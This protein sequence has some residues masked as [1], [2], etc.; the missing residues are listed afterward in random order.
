M[1]NY[2]NCNRACNHCCRSHCS[3]CPY[4]LTGPP[5]PRGCPG[6]E[7]I[8]GPAGIDGAAG[9]TGATGATGPAPTIEVGE[10]TIGDPGSAPIIVNSGTPEAAVFDF[11]FPPAAGLGSYGGVYSNEEQI[12]NLVPET[13]GRVEM[14][15]ALPGLNMTHAVDTLIIDIPGD[16]QLHFVIE[17]DMPVS[18]GLKAAVRINGVGIPQATISKVMMPGGEIIFM[19][20]TLVTLTAGDVVDL[21]VS[22][23]IA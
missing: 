12:I 6:P 21:A 22:P 23:L 20:N 15:G 1:Y 8:Q 16:Y 11:Q 2:N 18:A 9:L 19:V 17:A 13:E 10:I 4:C 14:T 7:G 3:Q 5:G